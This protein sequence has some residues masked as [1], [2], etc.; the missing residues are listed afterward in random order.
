MS[1]LNKAE[2][3]LSTQTASTAFQLAWGAIS[4]LGK[5]AWD[6]ATLDRAMKRYARGYLSRHGRVKV[7][8]MTNPI[9]L[10]SI[11]TAVEVVPPNYRNAYSGIEAIRESLRTRKIDS[12]YKSKGTPGF[13]IANK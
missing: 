9:P 10:L 4:K 11:Y 13:A 1:S 8:G 3:Q 7:L 2:E 5:K 6:R 12:L